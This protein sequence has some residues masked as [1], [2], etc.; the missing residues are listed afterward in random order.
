[1]PFNATPR[2]CEIFAGAMGS[3]T[4]GWQGTLDKF[5]AYVALAAR[6]A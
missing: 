6:E 1:V 2:E 4:Q 5:E 3:M